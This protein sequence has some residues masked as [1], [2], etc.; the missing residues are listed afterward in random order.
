M[1]LQLQLQ[2]P[3]SN[4]GRV[5]LTTCLPRARKATTFAALSNSQPRSDNVNWVEATSSFFDQDKRPIM[6]FDGKI[7]IK[8]LLR[9]I[10]N[11]TN[12]F[13]FI[14]DIQGCVTCVMAVSSLF[15]IMIEISK[16]SISFLFYQ[17]SY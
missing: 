8:T 1:A 14:F 2:L 11:V 13:L 3:A 4:I 7:I 6:L 9:C 12:V 5:K 15:V 16:L 10:F 17:A